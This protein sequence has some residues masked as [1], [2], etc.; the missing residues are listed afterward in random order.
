[1][2]KKCKLSNFVLLFQHCLGS[3][4]FYNTKFLTSSPFLSY[5]CEVLLTVYDFF[6]LKL[7]SWR[8]L[9]IP[10]SHIQYSYLL[11]CIPLI[12]SFLGRS[13]T[14]SLPI[15]SLFLTFFPSKCFSLPAHEYTSCPKHSV[16]LWKKRILIKHNLYSEVAY[17]K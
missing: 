12:S 14:S 3:S 4:R 16:N 1:M 15:S 13:F 9:K 17:D 10:F 5:L 6:Y 7:F 2:K 11:F 8:S